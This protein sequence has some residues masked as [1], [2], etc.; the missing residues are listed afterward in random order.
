M[1]IIIIATT[2]ILYN[3]SI[4]IDKYYVFQ[5]VSITNP[6]IYKKK[7]ESYS[8]FFVEV[9]PHSL[10]LMILAQTSGVE[11]KIDILNLS[12]PS[13]CLSHHVKK[14]VNNPFL[15][16]ELNLFSNHLNQHMNIR[17]KPMQGNLFLSLYIKK[18]Q[19]ATLPFLS[20]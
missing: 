20:K 3:S 12:P 19:R 10:I 18:R 6:F 16:R 5:R 9:M 4:T 7:T 14:R 11:P 17:N 1:L 13:V 2:P 8:A 15:V